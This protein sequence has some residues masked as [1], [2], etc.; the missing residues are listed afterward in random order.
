MSEAETLTV[1]GTV[2]EIRKARW[3][4]LGVG[5]I[6]LDG[7]QRRWTCIASAQPW[8]F[9]YARSCW[10][11]FRAPKGEEFTAA[12]RLVTKRVNV[13]IDPTAPRVEPAWPDGAKEAWLLATELGATEIATQDTRT[14]EVWCPD[15]TAPQMDG[16]SPLIHHLEICH[17]V[18]IS[19][20]R[21]Y[22]ADGNW[23][24]ASSFAHRAHDRAHKHPVGGTGF[25][26][27]HVPEDLSII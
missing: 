2:Y 13:L 17:G 23:E 8:Q 5:S 15:Y 10:L 6:V 3:G 4:D 27:R 24:E 19:A 7:N 9:E 14:G 21:Q 1:D 22:E 25:A 12:P 11:R 18:D 16:I 20:L 26:H